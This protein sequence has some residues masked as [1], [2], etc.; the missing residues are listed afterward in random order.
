MYSRI[1]ATVC[2][3][4]WRQSSFYFI[5]RSTTLDSNYLEKKPFGRHND[6][7]VGVFLSPALLTLI[8]RTL[9]IIL[10]TTR[11]LLRMHAA[12]TK[13]AR[14]KITP[15]VYTHPPSLPHDGNRK[16]GRTKFKPRARENSKVFC[17][18]A[19]NLF[20]HICVSRY[21]ITG[22]FCSS[23]VADCWKI[24]KNWLALKMKTIFFVTTLIAL[25][26]VFKDV[27][28]HEKKRKKNSCEACL[29]NRLLSIYL[30]FFSL[31]E[32]FQ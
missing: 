29:F 8:W 20:T 23:W 27:S 1:R 15:S 28:L 25:V 24:V 14:A 2:I 5:P 11:W 21:I 32:N 4:F 26:F 18:Y 12:R 10:E 16:I 30:S 7:G 3:Y 6:D 13:C 9:F 17:S 31:F 19:G 22:H